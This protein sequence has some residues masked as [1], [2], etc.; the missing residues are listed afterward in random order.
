MVPA[1][2]MFKSERI[3][4]TMLRHFGCVFCR[5]GAALLAEIGN[6]LMANGVTLVAVGTGSPAMAHAFIQET[7]F[8]GDLYV[9]PGRKLY[10][11]LDCRRGL[12]YVINGKT[13]AAAKL[14]REEGH[15]PG[16]KAGDTLQLGGTFILSQREGV[17]FEHLE[18]VPTPLLPQYA[19]D[20]VN[21]QRVLEALK[22]LSV[23]H[24]EQNQ[25][26]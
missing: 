2:A 7:G 11:A 17:L 21:P 13:L 20:L 24:D 16:K 3:V 26:F 9:D 8:K 19:G 12:K 5:K 22:G 14:A 23:I 6:E 10:A 15:S 4:L 1:E 25:D 18:A